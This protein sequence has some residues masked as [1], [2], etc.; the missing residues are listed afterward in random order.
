MLTNNKNKRGALF[1][2]ID[3]LVAAIALSLTVVILLSLFM[4]EPVT[5]DLQFQLTSYADYVMITDMRSYT[6][7]PGHIYTVSNDTQLSLKVHEQVSLHVHSDEGGTARSFVENFT[8]VIVGEQFGVQY[9][10]DGAVVY[11]RPLGEDTEAFM[12]LTTRMITYFKTDDGEIIGP[13]ITSISLW[14]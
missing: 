5:E 10:I 13:N 6:T 11:S 4:V 9:S 12:N 3:T 7:T 1:F 2:T 14:I 8:R